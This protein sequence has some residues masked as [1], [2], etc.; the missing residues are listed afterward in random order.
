MSAFSSLSLRVRLC[1]SVFLEMFF[2]GIKTFFGTVTVF[3]FVLLVGGIAGAFVIQGKQHQLMNTE[4]EKASYLEVQQQ[5]NTQWASSQVSKWEYI[6]SR[7]P[8]RV[9]YSYLAELYEY[10]G[11]QELA[12]QA[13]VEAQKLD[14]N[15][16]YGRFPSSN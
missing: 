10:L 15:F 6:V 8:S 16:F 2:F 14:P 13:R 5:K 4:A 9:A 11:Q 7:I 3:T 1:C 12:S